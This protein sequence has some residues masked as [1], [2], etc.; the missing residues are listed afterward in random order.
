MST[1][2]PYL[3]PK[4]LAETINAISKEPKLG[5]VTFSLEGQSD[6]DMRISS[7]TGPLTQAGSADSS[8]RGRF[9]LLSDEPT[10]LLGTDRA[11]S[12]AEYV[13]HGLAGCYAV[14]LT[15]LAAQEG[16]ELT[17]V[18]VDLEFDVD[19]SGFLGI[20]DAVRPGAQQIRVD[21]AVESPG[22]PSYVIERLVKALEERSPIRDTL[23]NPVDVVTNL[24][25]MDETALRATA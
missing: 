4:A 25:S 21:V 6:G 10:S 2:K 16:V 15:A 5:H 11:V 3:D 20:D 9:T 1:N 8:R 12:P 19:L 24:R 18:D 7:Q 17:K 14:T 23:A 13:L 22:T